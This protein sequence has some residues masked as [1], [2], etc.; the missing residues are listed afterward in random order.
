MEMLTIGIL[1]EEV[2]YAEHLAAFLGR[3]QKW[4]VQAFTWQGV[5]TDYLENGR[6]DLIAGTDKEVMLQ[7][8]STYPEI[9]MVWLTD[10]VIRRSSLKPEER[11]LYPV[12]RYQSA[13]VIG[14]SIREITGQCRTVRTEGKKMLAIYSPVGRCGKTT[15][16]LRLA[17]KETYGSLLYIGMEDYSFL[18]MEEGK[19]EVLYDI[20]ERNEKQMIQEI[21]QCEGILLSAYSPFDMRSISAEDIR[22]LRLLLEQSDYTGAIFDLGTGMVK[23]FQILSEFDRVIVPYLPDEKSLSKRKKWEWILKQQGLHGMEDRILYMNMEDEVEIEMKRKQLL[24]R[25]CSREQAR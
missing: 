18:D 4:K 7:L 1:D 9:V 19:N 8:L 22:W 11:G 21:M 2:Y 6:L 25:N 17:R 24:L 23:N 3:Y 14:Q 16:A 13:S 15:F 5:L 20:K 12:F 10:Q